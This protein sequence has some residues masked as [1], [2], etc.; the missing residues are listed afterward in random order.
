MIDGEILGPFRLPTRGGILCPVWDVSPRLVSA[1]A[2]RW[3]AERLPPRP[4]FISDAENLAA[5]FN[6]LF[7]IDIIFFGENY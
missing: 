5:I 3:R 1:A 4:A 2:G 7:Q 6:C